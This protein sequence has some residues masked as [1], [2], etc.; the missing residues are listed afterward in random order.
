MSVSILVTPQLKKLSNTPTVDR[1]TAGAFFEA[2]T[3]ID[4]QLQT[5]A[6]NIKAINVRRNIIRELV[7]NAVI[8]K[9]VTQCKDH[10][11][12]MLTTFTNAF[13]FSVVKHH[14]FYIKKS[15]SFNNTVEE[16]LFF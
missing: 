14:K 1:E 11:M 4:K 9:W 8:T 7:R 15:K 12:K 10:R 6:F 3:V 13:T 2:A 16:L 5:Y